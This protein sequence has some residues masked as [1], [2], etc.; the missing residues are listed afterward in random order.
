MRLRPLPFLVLVWLSVQVSFLMLPQVARAQS[1][2]NMWPGQNTYNV[3]DE[4]VVHW[5]SSDPC[6]QNTGSTG[7]LSATGPYGSIGTTQLSQSQLEY[8]SWSL[9]QAEQEDIGTWTITLTVS[10][11]YECKSSGSTGFQ[12]IGSTCVETPVTITSTIASTTTASTTS[13]MLLHV[14]TTATMTA[15]TTVTNTSDLTF[16]QILLTV[17]ATA[18]VAGVASRIYMSKKHPIIRITQRRTDGRPG[19]AFGVDV[20]SGVDRE[21]PPS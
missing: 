15:T 17:A 6:I 11:Q 19:P 16:P 9:G 4:I 7:Q 3:G 12:V 21:V 5:D 18:A 2:I 1:K 20:K 8:G 14:S 13:L 10:L